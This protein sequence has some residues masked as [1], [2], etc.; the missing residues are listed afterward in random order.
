[1][2]C[3]WTGDNEL[4]FHMAR[5]QGV[6]EVDDSAEPGLCNHR[7]KELI[8]RPTGTRVS[9]EG[10]KR[11]QPRFGLSLFRALA[12]DAYLTE[13]RATP[14]EVERLDAGARLIWHPTLSHRCKVSLEVSFREPC[15]VDLD[16]HV[17]AHAHYRDYELLLSDYLAPGF[18]A[19]AYVTHNLHGGDEWE[20]IPVE[21][22]PAFHGMY[23]FFPRDERSGHIL[24]DGRGQ[25]GRWHWRVAV[26]RYYARPMVFSSKGPVDALLMGRRD[27]VG[28]VGSTYSGDEE[29]DGVADHRAIYLSLFGNDVHP[30][31]GLRT[32]ARLVV[33]GL[34]AD[35][36]RHMALLEEFNE[37]VLDRGRRFEVAPR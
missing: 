31:Q 7:L 36:A 26:G 19:G 1:M 21:D 24:T 16:L 28:A 27:D 11:A 10:C 20:Q 33:D 5:L 23:N 3:E 35:P 37:E 6:L 34:Q 22:D 2:E 29:R 4:T 17:E 25:R 9:T 8:H 30:G 32:Q 13:P 14:V 18:R 15:A 12:R